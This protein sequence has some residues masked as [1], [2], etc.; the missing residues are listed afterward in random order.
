MMNRQQI[1]GVVVAGFAGVA[2][3]TSESRAQHAHHHPDKL[4]RYC[5]KACDARAKVCNETYK[6]SF[7]KGCRPD[8]RA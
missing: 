8:R 5:L 4:H 2:S 6:H 1:L 7:A 3:V